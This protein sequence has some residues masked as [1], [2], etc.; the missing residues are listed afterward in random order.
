MKK[1]LIGIWNYHDVLNKNGLFISKNP[2]YYLGE[3]SMK[4]F[5]N[6]YKNLLKKD[7]NFI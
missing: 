7:K 4:S 5:Y 2:G 1:K 6:V 3:D